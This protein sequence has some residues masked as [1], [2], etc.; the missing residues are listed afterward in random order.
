MSF[1]VGSA[2]IGSTVGNFAT[3]LGTLCT[4]SDWA[5][6][7]EGTE[8][9]ASGSAAHSEGSNTTASDWASHAEG[10]GTTANHA[11]QHVFGQYNIVDNSSAASTSRGN[12]IEVV[13]NGTASNALSNARTLDWSGNET[14]AGNLTLSGSSSDILFTGT[15]K[16]DGINKSLNTTLG[17]KLN[18]S[19]DEITGTLYSQ[20]SGANFE[21]YSPSWEIT[22]MGHKMRFTATDTPRSGIYDM[23]AGQW[24]FWKDADGYYR[25]GP[26]GYAVQVRPQAKGTT[27]YNLACGIIIGYRYTA[28][29]TTATVAYVSQWTDGSSDNVIYQHH[30]NT[31]NVSIYTGGTSIQVQ[32]NTNGNIQVIMIGR[33]RDA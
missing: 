11:Y 25:I 30:V 1:V 16:W 7:A 6:H 31:I 22:E 5:S 13:G 20:T 29:A 19:G 2:A 23:M 4:A 14:I 9:T 27:T 8:T 17:A 32:N 18:K 24:A 28:S 15:H 3:I 33:F 10:Y 26:N 21:V 12:Y